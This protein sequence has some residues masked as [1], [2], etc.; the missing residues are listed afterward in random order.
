MKGGTV[1]AKPRFVQ[2]SPSNSRKP[3]FTVLEFDDPLRSI[4]LRRARMQLL[5]KSA[6]IEE[7]AIDILKREHRGDFDARAELSAR[8]LNG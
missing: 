3:R 8:T 6:K 4:L 5:K 1:T 2:E 7:V